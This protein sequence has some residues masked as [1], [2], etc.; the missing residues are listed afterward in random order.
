MMEANISTRML[1]LIHFPQRL[2]NTP[3]AKKTVKNNGTDKAPR[4]FAVGE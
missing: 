1:I 3:R 4:K 2:G